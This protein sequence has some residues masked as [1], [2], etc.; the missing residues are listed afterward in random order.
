MLP[1]AMADSSAAA[2]EGGLPDMFGGKWKTPFRW[3]S[4]SDGVVGFERYGFASSGLT[5]SG[6]KRSFS[7]SDF[8][9]M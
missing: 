1:A 2:G 6:G 7:I 4:S 8:R 3:S 5:R 9:L